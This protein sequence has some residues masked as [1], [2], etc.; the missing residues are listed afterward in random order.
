MLR[1]FTT[2]LMVIIFGV[3]TEIA[4]SQLHYF[5]T[6]RHI[7]HYHFSYSRYLFLLLFP[8]VATFVTL[9]QN[10]NTLSK[11]FISFALLGTFLEWLIGFSYHMVVGQRL[12]TYH[13][14]SL[15]G[16]TSVLSIPLWGLAGA[17][18]YLLGKTFV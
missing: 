17:L 15:N 18:F 10:G 13:R 9:G 8:L 12:W 7:K 16:Y 11:V 3:L 4:V 14:L 2:F 1:S 5:L 6:K